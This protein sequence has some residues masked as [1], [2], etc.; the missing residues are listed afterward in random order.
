MRESPTIPIIEGLLAG[1]ASIRAFDPAAMTVAK[2]LLP[3]AVTYCKDAYE[4]AKGADCLVIATEWNQFRALEWDR[5][6]DLLREPLVVDLR[7]LYEPARVAAAG[8]RYV[9][10]GRS[11]AGA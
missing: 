9:S 7:N 6:R 4:A 8:F 11:E 10:V 5:L 1:G 3:A 2:G